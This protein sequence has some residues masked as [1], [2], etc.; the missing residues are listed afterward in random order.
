MGVRRWFGTDGIRGRTGKVPMTPEFVAAV[1]A[2]AGKFFAKDH[3]GGKVLVARDTRGSGPALEAA[4]AAGLEASG[5]SVV[6]VGVM[7]SGA[8]AMIVPVVGACAGAI[9]SASHN[10]AGDNGLKFCRADGRKLE[11]A[12]EE[13]IE[14]LLD[15]ENPPRAGAQPGGI[16]F[17]C[18][19]ASLESYRK[20]LLAGFGAGFTLK[21]VKVMVDA[22]NGA[23]WRT[24]PEILRGLGAEVEAMGDRPD[25]KNINEGCGSEH[26]E[27]LISAVKAKSGWIGIAHDGD[28]DRLLLVDEQGERVDGDE[29]IAMAALDALERGTLSGKTVVVTVMSNLGLEEA[30]AAKGGKVRRTPVGDRY[31]AAAMREGGFSVGGESS[32]HLLFTD[33]SPAGDG[34]LSALKILDLMKR[35]GQPLSQLRKVMRGY[36]QKLVNLKVRHKPAWESVPALAAAVREMEMFLGGKGRI[37]LRYSGTEPK[38]RLLVEADEEDKI[39]K[40]QDRLV[41]VLNEHLGE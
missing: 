3:P 13:K 27:G 23:A 34:L 4:L 36:P 33:V 25:G 18:A 21:G 37:L 29:V 7:P 6:R 22:A 38:V 1:G 26:P 2:A 20:K 19:P 17:S 39:R 14:A 31:V 11:D 40:V 28:A 5:L 35:K 16:D 12:E 15:L 30:M 32:G 24:T 8:A 9:L 10:P 41:P